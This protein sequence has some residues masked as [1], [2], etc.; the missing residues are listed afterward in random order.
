MDCVLSAIHLEKIWLM[1]W[2]RWETYAQIFD[3]K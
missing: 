2:K 1:I 3:Q